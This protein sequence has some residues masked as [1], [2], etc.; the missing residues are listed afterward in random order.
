MNFS[1]FIFFSFV[2]RQFVP[3]LLLHTHFFWLIILCHL[4][5]PFLLFHCVLLHRYTS[6]ITLRKSH[7]SSLVS[8]TIHYLPS[9]CPH[10]PVSNCLILMFTP[11]WTQE[12]QAMKLRFTHEKEC[13]ASFFEVLGIFTKYNSSCFIHLL[14]NFMTLILYSLI[15]FSCVYTYLIFFFLFFSWWRSRLN[16]FLATLNRIAMNI[17]V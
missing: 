16:H 15:I 9:I 2:S 12:T 8:S 3:F 6:I 5:C 13:A 1:L 14:L 4:L 11:G 10:W 7:L 17:D